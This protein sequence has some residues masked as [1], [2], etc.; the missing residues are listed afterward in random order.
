MLFVLFG[1][2]LLI[3]AGIAFLV[4]SRMRSIVQ[5][6]SAAEAASASA[7]AADRYR[8]ML[9][10]L[11]DEDLQ[12]VPAHLRTAVCADRRKLFRSYLQCL[13]KD[14]ARLL[15]GIRMAMV[16]SGMDRPE[17]ARALAKN[18]FLFVVALCRIEYRLALHA[19]GLGRVD[20][21]GLVEA[22]DAL[23]TQ[24]AA[25]TPMAAGAAA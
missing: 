15:G 25:F 17:L 11:S 6:M 13:A 5:A 16:R 8:P 3:I 18:R 4:I 9:R 23:R 19:A 21:S 1:V 12:F 2:L 14:Y 20:V 24:V 7:V 10:L 22:L